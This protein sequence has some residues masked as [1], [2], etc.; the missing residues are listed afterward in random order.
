[1]RGD[2]RDF[3]KRVALAYGLVVLL[4]LL[5]NA[6]GIAAGRFP[7][8]DDALRLVELRDWLGGQGWFDVTQHRIDPAH[9]GVAMHW[10]RI[11][12][13]PLAMVVLAL[14]PLLGGAGAEMAALL[15]VPMLTLAMVLV[16]VARVAWERLGAEA[17]TLS[18][19]TLAMSV[20]VVTQ[21]RPMRID[22]HGWQVAAAM[23]ALQGLM[24]RHARI[25]GWVSGAALA[26]GLS[27]SLEGLPLTAVFGALGAWRWLR[28]GETRD[29]LAHFATGLAAVSLACFAATRWGDWA[30]HCDA[31]A[32]VHLAMFVW[33]AVVLRLWRGPALV[34]FAIT[35]AGAL[36]LYVGLAPQCRGGSFN[37]LDPLV[38]R[39]WYQQVAEGLPVWRQ[40]WATAL[41][42]VVPPL[43]A[44]FACAGLIQRSAGEERVWWQEYT[45]ILGGALGV[46]VL[47]TRAGAVAGAFSAVPLAWLVGEWLSAARRGQRL[48]VLGIVAAMVPSAPITV[49][50]MVPHKASSPTTTTAQRVSTCE[51]RRHAAALNTLPQ[52][53]IL[54]PL[55]IGPDLLLG[56]HDSVLATGHHRGARGMHDAIAAFVAPPDQARAIIRANHIAYVALCPDLGEPQIYAR[57]APHG[58]AADLLAGRAP[59]WLAP[60]AADG[61]GLRIWRVL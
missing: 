51:A 57:E 60:V 20:P 43:F 7:D 33:A 26:I 6:G 25:G 55:D 17:A 46:A 42:T 9:G 14:R 61:E 12:D 45:L 48:A 22:H 2:F 27:I 19:L 34:G 37:M 13:V 38:Q 4:L 23:L 40:D 32:P 47:V 18:C 10:S 35:G 24:T 21:I 8:P 50:G 29:W 49:W 52:G 1:M 59:S 39:L 58:L 5:T 41:Q 11:V 15:I 44:L 3:L 16:L 53:T 31:I 56:S 36:A 54:A 30:Q 28:G